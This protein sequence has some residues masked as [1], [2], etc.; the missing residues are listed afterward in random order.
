M[1]KGASGGTY[2]AGPVPHRV[3]ED[4]RVWLK[5][6]KPESLQQGMELADDYTLAQGTGRSAG[7]KSQAAGPPATGS[8]GGRADASK[9]SFQPRAPVMEGCTQTNSKGEKRCFQC[10]KHGHLMFNCSSKSVP[11]TSGASR[12]LYAKGCDEVAWNEQSR[13][14]LRRG[15]LDGRAVQMLVE[16]GGSQTMVSA[17]LVDAA[18]ISSKEKVP[19]LCAHCD[20][21]LYPTAVVQVQTGP[22]KRES[23]GRG[24]KPSS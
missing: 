16:S 14:Y 6:R 23:S 10:G 12:I 18:K 3:L 7:R 1:D 20:T 17:R 19:I 4:L 2:G 21:V 24:P 13:K 22:W 9:P 11:T 5:E 15:N 8:T